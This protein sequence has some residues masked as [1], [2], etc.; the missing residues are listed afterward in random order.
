MKCIGPKPIR[1][2]M[3]DKIAGKCKYMYMNMILKTF[4]ER[5]DPSTDYK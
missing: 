5:S 4:R 3:T 2:V 1:S